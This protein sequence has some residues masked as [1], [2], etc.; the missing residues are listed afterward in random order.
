MEAEYIADLLA[1]DGPEIDDSPPD[2]QDFE[3][4]YPIEDDPNYLVG[5]D[6]EPG[7]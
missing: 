5:H 7:E 1:D 2:G 4:F 6:L 3:D